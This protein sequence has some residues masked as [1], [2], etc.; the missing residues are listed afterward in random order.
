[1][2]LKQATNQ[3]IARQVM[4]W[5]GKKHI[6]G[7]LVNGFVICGCCG[8]IFEIDT[9]LEDAHEDGVEPM[10]YFKTWFNVSD[11][12]EG[13]FCFDDALS[14]DEEENDNGN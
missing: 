6:P 11:G 10:R 9:I 7:I 14:F 12:I 2:T 13:D 4:F 5:D 3:G 1:M 8:S